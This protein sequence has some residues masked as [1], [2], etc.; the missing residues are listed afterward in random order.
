MNVQ[1]R[2]EEKTNNGHKTSLVTAVVVQCKVPEVLDSVVFE[3]RKAEVRVNSGSL[4]LLVDG[5]IVPPEEFTMDEE[6]KS[7]FVTLCNDKYCEIA[8]K[9]SSNGY[10]YK[11]E[12]VNGE[13]L[14]LNSTL[15][16]DESNINVPEGLVGKLYL[17]GND[18]ETEI[19]DWTDEAELMLW[20]NYWRVGAPGSDAHLL[21][22]FTYKDG[23]T[24]NTYNDDGETFDATY[25][26]EVSSSM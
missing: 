10:S 15:P 11:V 8:C 16:S 20:G 6:I 13:Y 2:M 1:V 3:S 21:S 19:S 24:W 18:D 9:Q 26:F 7:T 14:Q 23:E 4:E 12:M 25:Y 17:D 5:T 22:L